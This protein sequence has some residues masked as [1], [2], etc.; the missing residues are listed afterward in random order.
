MCEGI[1]YGYWI[2]NAWAYVGQVQSVDPKRLAKRHRAHVRVHP[3][4]PAPVILERVIGSDKADLLFNLAWQETVWIF[5]QHTYRRIWPAG[6]N[7]IVPWAE[8]YQVCGRLGGL[9]SGRTVG[10]IANDAE[11]QA[12]PNYL[13]SRRKGGLTR[14]HEQ[15]HRDLNYSHPTCPLCVMEA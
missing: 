13:E 9:I 10:R 8:D 7:R 5:K 14:S 3:A 1:I 15:W 12:N 6:L 2:L 11:H 4:W